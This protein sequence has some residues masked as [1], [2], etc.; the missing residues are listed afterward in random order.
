MMSLTKNA[1]SLAARHSPVAAER[2]RVSRLTRI[3]ACTCPTHSV[4]TKPSPGANTSTQRTSSRER[5]F[6]SAVRTLSSGAVVSH[7]AVTAWCKAGW[8]PLSWAIR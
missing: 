2:V 8:L 7:S 6:L 4:S 1:V 3:T 5:R